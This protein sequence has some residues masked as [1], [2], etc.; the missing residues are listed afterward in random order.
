MFCFLMGLCKFCREKTNRFNCVEFDIIGKLS[1]FLTDKRF[2]V[3][4]VYD[5]VPHLFHVGE[6]S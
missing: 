3:C 2:A 1:L 5:S 6:V 4:F